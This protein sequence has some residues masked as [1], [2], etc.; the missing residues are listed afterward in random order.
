MIQGIESVYERIALAMLD[1][2]PSEWKES[3]VL[4]VFYEDHIDFE[5]DFISR[6]G[7]CRSYEGSLELS[8]A[9]REL[10]QRFKDNCQPVW[11][12]VTF[13]LKSD[14]S[15]KL[16]FGYDSLD[17]NGNTIWNIDEYQRRHNER[18]SRLN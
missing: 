14:F 12:Q 6:D 16:K 18:T 15:I 2:L 3:S 8:Q 7:R 9:I 13:T 4:A 11:G 5:T 10:R 1:E 17:E